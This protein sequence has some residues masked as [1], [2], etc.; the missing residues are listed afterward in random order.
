MERRDYYLLPMLIAA[1]FSMPLYIFDV[2]AWNVGIGKA[3]PWRSKI[4]AAVARVTSAFRTIGNFLWGHRRGL[5]IAGVLICILLFAPRSS[6]AHDFVFVGM[7]GHLA[8]LETDLVAKQAEAKTLLEKTMRACA[9][10]VVTPASADGKTPEVKGR[11]MTTEEKAAIQAILDDGKKIKSK[12]DGLQGDHNLQ[13]EI[14][15]L[16]SG[17]AAA[18]RQ[19]NAERIARETRSI[20]QQFVADPLYQAWVKG[21]NHRQ[22][23]S[24]SPGVEVMAAT[25]TS[26]P[27]SGGTVILPDNRPGIIELLFKR[28]VIADLIAPGTTDSN[29]IAYMKEKTFTN[30]ADAVL[31]GGLKPESTLVFE[32]ATSAVRKIAH[33]IPVTEEMLEDFKQTA[34]IIDSRLRLGLELKEEDELLN[35]TG[36]APHLLGLMNLPG[37]TAAQA[38]GADSNMDAIF[39]QMTTIATTVFSLTDGIV[40][41]PANW[42]TVQLMKNAA[43]NYMGSG[44]WAPAQNPTLWGVP[45][46]VTPSIVAGTALVGAF[47]SAAQIFRKGGIR[48]ESSNS[49]ASFFVNNLVA[50]RAE[51]RLALAVYREAAFGK[52]T[53]LA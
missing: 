2:H 6:H 40:V 28:M 37:L 32:A 22:K 12:I 31:E 45:V 53:G 36:I 34:S 10:H 18:A 51:E 33:W 21:E 47:R 24:L 14:E 4:S 39:K 44:P 17:M 42:Q 49:H 27:A 3:E 15:R 1:I 35:G 29:Q 23:G 19:G 7:A 43:G 25:L 38:R 48:V 8:Q 50:I 46:A 52:V 13:Q 9:D 11:L 20:G 30:A 26:D 41:N 16:T 5:A